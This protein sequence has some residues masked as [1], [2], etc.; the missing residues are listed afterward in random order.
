MI[1]REFLKETNLFRELTEEELLEILLIGHLQ[2]YQP[3]KTIFKEGDPGDTLYLIVRGNVRISKM[4]GKHEEALAILE[5]KAFFGEMTLLDQEA[6][7]SAFA[8]AHTR[9]NLFEIPTESLAKLFEA[10]R[11]IGYKFLW[12]FCKTLTDRLRNAN[13][14]MQVIMSLA[15]SG[16]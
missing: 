9:C 4:D 7:R 6:T 12:A 10:N 11:E 14:K 5:E 1:N 8:I 3:D 15:N 13:E 16:F 2:T